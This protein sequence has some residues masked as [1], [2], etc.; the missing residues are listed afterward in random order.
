M[1]KVLDM[2][3]IRYANIFYNVTRIKTKNC[4]EYN[5]TILF[6]VPRNLVMTAIGPNSRNLEKLSRIIGKKI[7]IVACPKGIEDLESFV[8]II[9]RPV[10]FKGIEIRGD[11][12]I[13]NANM[14]SK[15]SL[16]GRGKIRLQEME[17]ILGQYFG[18]RKIF[19]R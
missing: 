19:I 14:Q 13:I 3:F 15:A 12:I 8:S 18:I 10:K 11:E 5:N 9:T 16:I 4:F 7:K 17:N 1:I 6:V 2:R